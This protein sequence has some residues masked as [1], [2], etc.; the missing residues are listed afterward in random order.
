[1]KTDY[2]RIAEDLEKALA[3]I[4]ASVHERTPRRCDSIATASIPELMNALTHIA[5][6]AAWA[7]GL[8]ETHI[9]SLAGAKTDG[10]TYPWPRDAN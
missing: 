4:M 8:H 1:M 3:E 10:A 7:R 5:R 9:S 2:L 6:T